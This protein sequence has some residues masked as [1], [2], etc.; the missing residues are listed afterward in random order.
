MSYT[1]T[2]S[3]SW[4]SRMSGGFKAI[5]I[6]LLLVIGMVVML[7][8]NE[9]RA[10]KTAKALAEGAAA[11]IS[12][13]ATAPD[14]ANEGKI[15]HIAGNVT[16]NGAPQDTAL[17]I[18]APGAVALERSVEMYQWREVR[19]SETRTK[20]GGGEETVTTYSYEKVWSPSPISSSNFKIPAGHHN[21]AFP[22]PGETFTIPSVSLGGFQ[23]SGSRAASIAS[24]QPVALDPRQIAAVSRA[25]SNGG[26]YGRNANGIIYFGDPQTPQIG[27][28]RI[29]F[30]IKS[31]SQASFVAAQQ[32][33][34]LVP[35]ETSNGREIF[36]SQPGINEASAMFDDAITSNTV[37]TWFLRIL[38]LVLMYVGFRLMLSIIGIAGDVIPFIGSILRMGTGIVAFVLTALLGPL[39]IALG[40]FA[41]RPL[42]SIGIMMVGLTVAVFGFGWGRKKASSAE[43]ENPNSEDGDDTEFG[44]S[45]AS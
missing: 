29:S 37:F 6:G 27:D 11:V 19:R 2:T 18:S 10:V 23:I 7:F 26:R 25:A 4:F 45:A 12:V 28:Y 39:I 22:W 34:T 24:S 8:W 30:A 5:F 35:Y 41:Y 9:G 44:R 42:L 1:E 3:R 14:P 13:D 17:G 31:L 33:S 38:G 43:Q 36:L 32:G 20:I 15:V 40:W 16:P 21:P